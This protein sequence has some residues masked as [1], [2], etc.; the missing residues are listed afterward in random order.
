MQRY[1]FEDLCQQLRLVMLPASRQSL[2]RVIAQRLLV[3]P[4]DYNDWYQ[5]PARIGHAD[6]LRQLC[7]RA[8]NQ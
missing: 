5:P 1:T 3:T 6:F 8:T 4:T 7:L 2:S